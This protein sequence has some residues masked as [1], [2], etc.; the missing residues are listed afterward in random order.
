MHEA[1]SMDMRDIYGD[2][3]KYLQNIYVMMGFPRVVPTDVAI[4]LPSIISC[5]FVRP[6][7]EFFTHIF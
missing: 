7:L 1:G 3:E 4:F 5:V 2:S 6:R